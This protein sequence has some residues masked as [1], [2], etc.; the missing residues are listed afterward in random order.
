MKKNRK[1]VSTR[2][3]LLIIACSAAVPFCV[4]NLYR[5]I[6]PAARP[7]TPLVRSL[8][9]FDRF[10]SLEGLTIQVDN[11][12]YSCGGPAGAVACQRTK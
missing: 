11:H 8:G 9:G 1:T 5:A 2:I 12:T 3:A 10:G 7:G 6:T 4:L